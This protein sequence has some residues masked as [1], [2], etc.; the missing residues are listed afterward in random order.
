[1]R[2]AKARARRRLTRTKSGC[3]KKG[4]TDG[5]ASKATG[6]PNYLI[7]ATHSFDE[8]GDG[9]SKNGKSNFGCLL[10]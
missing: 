1:M 6:R 10:Q 8:L 7:R 9:E 4:M 3:A 5:L 2:G